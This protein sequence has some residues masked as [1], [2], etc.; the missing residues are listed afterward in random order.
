MAE[1]QNGTLVF[2]MVALK[3]FV[4]RLMMIEKAA[5]SLPKFLGSSQS[6]SLSVDGI[7]LHCLSVREEGQLWEL[8]FCFVLCWAEH[9][10]SLSQRGA[11]VAKS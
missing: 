4:D 11:D 9:P 1:C 8:T 7:S 3:L 2:A 10:P 5:S 6:L